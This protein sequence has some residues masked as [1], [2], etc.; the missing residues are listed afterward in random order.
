MKIRL[1]WLGLLLG[2]LLP[3]QAW[4][5]AAC[6]PVDCD[7]PRPVDVELNCEPN[8]PY[9]NDPPPLFCKQTWKQIYAYCDDECRY[10]VFPLVPNGWI[11]DSDATPANYCKSLTVSTAGPGT[12][13]VDQGGGGGG[14]TCPDTAPG[15]VRNTFL[16]NRRVKID[17]NPTTP[18]TNQWLF[19]GT[20]K[21]EVNRK[22]PG[23]V[24]LDQGCQI[25]DAD[26][27]KGMYTYTSANNTLLAGAIGRV[28]W[29]K[30]YGQYTQDCLQATMVSDISA[31]SLSP[32]SMNLD[33]GETRTLTVNIED[34]NEIDHVTFGKAGSPNISLSTNRVD[35]RNNVTD[36]YSVNITGVSETSSDVVVTVRVFLETNVSVAACVSTMT[37]SVNP[38]PAISVSGTVRT[39]D[40]GAAEL[41]GGKC[42]VTPQTSGFRPGNT[43][44]VAIGGT[45]ADTVAADGTYSITTEQSDL[46]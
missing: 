8:V 40:S 39:D 38:A 11:C 16:T 26:L 20:G 4:A 27:G 17:W 36:V 18:L 41:V 29:T 23:G 6:L 42:T 44:S 25:A 5:A 45:D 21:S 28:Y 32:T 35:D 31:C 1:I 2:L 7:S 15:N 34:N 10:G 3:G 33:V 22:C 30:I 43:S 14:G 46:S 24:G 13:C 9:D 19:F 12:C 37:V